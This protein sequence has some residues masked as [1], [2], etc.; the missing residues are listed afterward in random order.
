MLSDGVC[1]PPLPADDYLIA[2]R[3]PLDQFSFDRNNSR[4]DKFV[5]GKLKTEMTS[6]ASFSFGFGGNCWKLDRA[7]LLT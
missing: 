3:F 5:P 6:G 1:A 7:G 4:L 2:A